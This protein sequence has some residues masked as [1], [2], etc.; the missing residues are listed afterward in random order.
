L[1]PGS[2]DV[3]L[4]A[5]CRVTVPVDWSEALGSDYRGRVRF[6]RRFHSPTGLAQGQRVYLCVERAVTSGTISLNGRLLGAVGEAGPFCFDVTEN[7][8]AGNML[9]IEIE[10]LDRA[11]FL[12]SVRLEIQEQGSA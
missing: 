11:G 6:T 1:N 8:A 9:S 2:A 5:A 4:P 12:G 10:S 7:L 3:S